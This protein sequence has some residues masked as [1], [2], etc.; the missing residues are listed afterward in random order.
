M[1]QRFQQE[2]LSEEEEPEDTGYSYQEA[3]SNHHQSAELLN[4]YQSQVPGNASYTTGGYASGFNDDG[5]ASVYQQTSHS[6][7]Q[8]Q[9]LLFQDQDGKSFAVG[10]QYEVLETG[11]DQEPVE[12]LDPSTVCPFALPQYSDVDVDHQATNV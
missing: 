12:R 1:T 5:A 9:Q 6:L 4:Q 8:R 3:R 10:R 2:S 11:N 7:P